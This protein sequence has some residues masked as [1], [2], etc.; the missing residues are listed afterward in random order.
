MPRR[1]AACDTRLVAFG[2][3]DD[4]LP[5]GRNRIGAG[6]GP[7]VAVFMA[8]FALVVTLTV[9]APGSRGHGRR[10]HMQASAL[11]EVDLDTDVASSSTAL[12]A[13]ATSAASGRESTEGAVRIVLD[14]AVPDAGAP[15]ADRLSDFIAARRQ[16]LG[17]MDALRCAGRAGLDLAEVQPIWRLCGRALRQ[18][19]EASF[20]AEIA[21][22]GEAGAAV[23]DALDSASS[24]ES[25]DHLRT[26]LGRSPGRAEQAI[27]LLVRTIIAVTAHPTRGSPDEL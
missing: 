10:R 20:A 24:W 16:L 7:A 6:L 8:L 23:R 21:S 25:W 1:R 13:L 2:G 26:D 9:T 22:A 5:G 3:A 11:A 14:L 19:V 15:L 4:G 18:H 27:H 12:V 17:A